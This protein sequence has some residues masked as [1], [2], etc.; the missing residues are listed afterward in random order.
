MKR[1]NKNL[2]S[3]TLRSK[4]WWFLLNKIKLQFRP[5]ICPFDILLNYIA[6][7]KRVFD[8]GCGSGLFLS[9]V[10]AHKKPISIH[11]VDISPQLIASAQSLLEPYSREIPVGLKIYD[12]VNLPKTIKHSDIVTM[13][14]IFHHLPPKSRRQYIRQLFSAMSNDSK[15]IFKDIDGSSFFVIGNKIHDFLLT[16]NIPKEVAK[17]TMKE[18]LIDAGF[19]IIDEASKRMLWYPHYWIICQ[20]V[21]H[22]K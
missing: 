2:H 14:D 5:Y 11:G 13:I 22:E 18:L 15:L 19:T 6:E 3:T 21:A 16:G 9:L 8:I 1:D 4:T 12:G 20:K 17:N 7:N 10:A